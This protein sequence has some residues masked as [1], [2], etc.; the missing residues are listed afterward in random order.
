M[1]RRRSRVSARSDQAGAI[2]KELTREVE[3]VVGK[4]QFA[5]M[6]A[7]AIETP[8]DT[9]F[10][11]AGWTPEIGSPF[12][13]SLVPP[14]DK[15]EARTRASERRSRNFARAAEILSRY[16]L[17]M[18]RVFISNPVIYILALNAGSSA[19]APAAFV[20]RAIEL[21]VRSFGGQRIS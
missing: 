3:R 2:S 18:G 19:Q 16:R 17:G 20:E 1:A 14:D 12:S 13:G 21:V 6:Q 9:G 5:L 4:L 8:V 7:L 10:A 11:R 15:A